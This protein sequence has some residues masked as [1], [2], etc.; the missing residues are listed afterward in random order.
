VLR[1]ILV[2]HGQTN[3][4][5]GG[6]SGEHFRGRIDIG[7]NATGV[8]QAQS[9]AD[10]LALVDVAA[11][12]AS[13]LQRA[14]DTAKPIAKRHGLPLHPFQALLDIDYGQWG[15]RSHVEVAARW[16]ELYH[17]WQTVPHTVQIPGGE[18]LEDVRAR[19]DAGLASL[20]DLYDRQVIVLVGHQ[21][22]NKVMVC[23]L[24]GLDNSAVWH[25][26]QETGCINR[27]DFDGQTATALTINEICHLPTHPPELDELAR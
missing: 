27:F 24:L 20:V 4:N 11:I 15:G 22:V 3:W 2:R 13:P 1:I 16:P 26:R 21:V 7:L 19:I 12:Y 23:K 10:C 5:D 6:P 17:Q 9:V 18:S 14:M 25:I 8:A